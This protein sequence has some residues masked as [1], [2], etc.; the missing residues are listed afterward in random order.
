[1]KVEPYLKNCKGWK[2]LLRQNSFTFKVD[3]GPHVDGENMDKMNTDKSQRERVKY[4]FIINCIS[5]AKR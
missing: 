4:F 1:M 5:V 3:F 2:M